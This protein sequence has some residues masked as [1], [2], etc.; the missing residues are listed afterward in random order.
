MS[1]KNQ[2]KTSAPVFLSLNKT[3]VEMLY[4]LINTVILLF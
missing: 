2:N 3:W 1:H 4:F